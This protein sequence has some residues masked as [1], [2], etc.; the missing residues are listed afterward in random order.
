M[1]VSLQSKCTVRDILHCVCD[2]LSIQLTPLC[3]FG[4]A[5]QHAN[6][7]FEFMYDGLRAY[8]AMPKY[9]L[10]HGKVGCFD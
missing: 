10:S 9:A 8:K 6:D 2:H 5:F 7:E 4:L 1:T 3:I